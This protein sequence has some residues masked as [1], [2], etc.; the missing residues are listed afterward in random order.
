MQLSFSIYY[1]NVRLFIFFIQGPPLTKQFNDKQW[2]VGGKGATGVEGWGGVR[3]GVRVR[4]GSNRDVHVHLSQKKKY[5][6]RL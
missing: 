4:L 3:S 1:M 5:I 6:F 2:C